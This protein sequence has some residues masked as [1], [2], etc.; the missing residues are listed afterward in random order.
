MRRAWKTRLAGCPARCSA[1]GVAAIS[2][3]TSCAEVEQRRDGPLAHDAAGVARGE[4]L[5]AVLVEDA[6][7]ARLVVLGEDAGGGQLGRVVHAHVERGILR[8][9]EAALDL[10]ELH[11]RDAEI[12][13]DARDRRDAQ[14]VEHLGDLVVDRVDEVDARRRTARGA[15]R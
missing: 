15:P 8:V 6:A 2:S 10:V 9:R 12:E 5:L 11:R 13:E 4:L 3:S 1:A 14:L 7:Q